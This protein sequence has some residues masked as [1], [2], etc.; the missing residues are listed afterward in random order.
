M[1]ISYTGRGALCAR[2]ENRN[3]WG[4]KKT[5]NIPLPRPPGVQSTH[6]YAMM[7]VL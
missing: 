6:A 4:K 5:K 3:E 7:K 2:S 1:Y